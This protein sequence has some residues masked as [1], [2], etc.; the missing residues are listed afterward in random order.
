MISYRLFDAIR[1]SNVTTLK[2]AIDF[3]LTLTF[4]KDESVDLTNALQSITSLINSPDLQSV[5][6]LKVLILLTDG[7]SDFDAASAPTSAKNLAD[8]RI[9]VCGVGLSSKV[10]SDV[11]KTLC[12]EPKRVNLRNCFWDVWMN[13]KNYYMSS[14]CWR[15]LK[16]ITNYL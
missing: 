15:F 14:G 6:K 12:S 10:K 5:P 9:G 7:G 13:A 3:N 4:N 11:L 16:W 1:Y 2:G 8:A